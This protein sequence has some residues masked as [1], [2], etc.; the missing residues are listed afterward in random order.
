MVRTATDDVRSPVRGV[1]ACR[2]PAVWG[3]AVVVSI[4]G[5]R[6]AVEIFRVRKHVDGITVS[7][8]GAVNPHGLVVC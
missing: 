7:G 3:Y 5:A 4:S 1:V 6:I 2:N 8:E